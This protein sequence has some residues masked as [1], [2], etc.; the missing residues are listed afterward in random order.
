MKSA[1]RPAGRELDRLHQRRL[2]L[3]AF[4]HVVSLFEQETD[5]VHRPAFGGHAERAVKRRP[6]GEQPII[7][8][9]FPTPSCI[10]VQP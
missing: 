2:A 9:I 5:R 4:L 7:A 3:K 6:G 8:F 10:G 1:R